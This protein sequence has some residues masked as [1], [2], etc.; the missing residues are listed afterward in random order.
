[1]HN[2]KLA[3]GC[4]A[5]LLF[6]SGC[7]IYKPAFNG[8]V[9]DTETKEPIEGAVVVAVYNKSTMGLGAGSVSGIVN[10]REAL[11]DKGGMFQIP[12]YT[13]IIQPFSW[14]TSATFII[15]KPG[16]GS[17]PNYRIKPSME[18]SNP[19]IEIF[20]S[21]EIGKEVEMIVGDGWWEKYKDKVTF[22]IV[23]LPKLKTRE[24]RLK[25]TPSHLTDESKTPILNRLIDEEDHNLGLK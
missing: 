7:M 23:E 19:A 9:M 12:S 20:F 4:I 1:M 22:G 24:E 21:E 17:F 11:T 2:K 10:V 6:L 18:L 13:T 5:A 14:A 25:A 15:F 8:K 16:Y 3:A